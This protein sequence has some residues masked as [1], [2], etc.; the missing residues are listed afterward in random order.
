[1][2][3]LE[4]AIIFAT[5]KHS[6]QIDKAGQPYILHP[7]RLMTKMRTDE[8]RIVAVLHDILEDTDAT[9]VDLISLGFSQDIISAVEAL[10]R[11]DGESRIE[12][13]WRAV[14]N[15]LAREVKLADVSDNLDINRISHPTERDFKRLKEYQQVQQILQQNA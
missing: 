12:A 6:G 11:R 7:L 1:M 15:P 4:K 9:V 14:K 3:N 5:R 2:A 8:Q 10:T 13:A